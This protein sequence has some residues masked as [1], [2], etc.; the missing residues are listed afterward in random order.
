MGGSHHKMSFL[1]HR[2]GN[3]IRRER[4]HVRYHQLL[5]VI[6]RRHNTQNYKNM[7]RSS[8]I[9]SY[10]EYSG[11]QVKKKSAIPTLYLV[12]IRSDCLDPLHDGYWGIPKSTSTTTF[13]PL[14]FDTPARRLF[15]FPWY[16]CCFACRPNRFITEREKRSINFQEH[17]DLLREDFLSSLLIASLRR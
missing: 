10:N 8:I 4:F 13:R 2:H 15:F 7:K 11:N 3:L 14:M 12:R 9:S 17:K 16:S 6:I 1:R 5:S